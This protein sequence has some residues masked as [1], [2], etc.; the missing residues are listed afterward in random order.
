MIDFD[1]VPA[2]VKRIALTCFLENVT[3]E[4]LFAMPPQ[5]KIDFAKDADVDPEGL[6]AALTWLGEYY[7]A[8]AKKLKAY[9]DARKARRCSSN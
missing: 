6:A 1:R 7:Q 4:H 3:H 8:H 9:V 2:N 5:E